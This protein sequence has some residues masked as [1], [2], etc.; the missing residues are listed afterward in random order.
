MCAAGQH[1]PAGTSVANPLAPHLSTPQE[2]K[3]RLAAERRGTPFLALRDGDGAQ[4]LF[5]LDPSRSPVTIGRSDRNDISIAWDGEVSRLHAEMEHI[6]GEWTISDDGLS[7]N[8]TY[9]NDTRITGRQRLADGDLIR[10]GRT[11]A[12]FRGHGLGESGATVT[13]GGSPVKL[14]LSPAQRRVL[15]ALCRPYKQ[16]GPFTAPPTNQEIADE[17]CVSVEAVKTQLRA[18]FA[19][20]EMEDLPQNMK[21]RRLVELAF[22]RGIVSH[23][24][25]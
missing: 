11:V 25:L 20:L 8:G 7:R 9:V 1:P 21:R 5:D 18:L 4:H 13:A 12:A 2:L 14:E 23:R 22:E 17:L 19:R 16:S 15:V 24:D 10:L 6:A 3:D